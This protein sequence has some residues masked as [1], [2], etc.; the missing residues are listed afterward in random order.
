MTTELSKAEERLIN[1]FIIWDKK[2]KT[3]ENIFNYI[4]L[5]LGIA[6][7]VMVSFFTFK[8]LHNNLILMATAPGFLTGIL[9]IWLFFMGKR[10]IKEY[11]LI[12]SILKKLHA[13]D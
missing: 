5:I 6:I 12:T 11:Q 13:Q 4:L 3:I 2:R 9:I 1:E 7:L 10:R 8:H